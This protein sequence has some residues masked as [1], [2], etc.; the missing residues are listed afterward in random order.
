ML[1]E[2]KM[3]EQILNVASRKFFAIGSSKVTVDEIAAE[4]RISKKT[5]YKHFASKRDILGVIVDQQMELAASTV[6]SIIESD[7]EFV[8]KIKRLMEFLAMQIAKIGKAFG[9]DVQKRAPD[10]WKHIE[11]FRQENAARNF[12]RLFDQ[13]IRSGMIRKEMNSGVVML[14]LVGSI[15]TVMTPEVLAHHSFSWEEAFR[16]IMNIFLRGILTDKACAKYERI[17]N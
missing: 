15:Q 2:N 9:E 13:G 12:S 1:S 17:N 4:L 3:R 11:E 8:E 14:M 16:T 5:L 6:R 7:V 10:L